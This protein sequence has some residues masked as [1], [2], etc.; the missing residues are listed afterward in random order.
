MGAMR[1]R[2]SAPICA[3][4]RA[5]IAPIGELE[6][7]YYLNVEVDDQPGVLAQVAAVF[8]DHSVSIRSMEQEGLGAGARL[9]FI[10]HAARESD[11]QATLHGLRRLGAVRSIGSVLRVVGD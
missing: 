11:L 10:T 2:S 9:V 4:E 6:S 3:L 8:G 1:A 7:A 5:R